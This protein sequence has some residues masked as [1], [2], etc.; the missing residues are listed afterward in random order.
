MS[1]LMANLHLE[2]RV[3]VCGQLPQTQHSNN[4]MELFCNHDMRIYFH[5][6]THMFY[7]YNI[8]LCSG[9]QECSK[10]KARFE[11]APFRQSNR[12]GC[13]PQDRVRLCLCFWLTVWAS[14]VLGL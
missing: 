10:P 1:I 14:R 9:L 6:H 7:V 4:N 3:A 11:A 2:F 12:E 8:G 13:S 5:V